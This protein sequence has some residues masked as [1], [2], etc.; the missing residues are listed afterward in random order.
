M[1][2]TRP[3]TTGIKL[4]THF[5]PVPR[6]GMS[7]A[8]SLLKEHAFMVWTVKTLH[9]N[10]KTVKHVIFSNHKLLSCAHIC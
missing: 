10:R 2:T 4:T 5:H 3:E 6:L 9:F 1:L 8:K 7:G